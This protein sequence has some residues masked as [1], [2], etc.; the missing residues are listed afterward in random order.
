MIMV[1]VPSI[2]WKFQA[3]LRVFLTAFNMVTLLSGLQRDVP[4]IFRKHPLGANRLLARRSYRD[5]V[6]SEFA[7]L[8]LDLNAD[9]KSLLEFG[10]RIPDLH[11][12]FD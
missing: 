4:G 5:T 12:P 7:V 6:V 2:L 3:A 11:V 10:F 8:V 9:P 1:T